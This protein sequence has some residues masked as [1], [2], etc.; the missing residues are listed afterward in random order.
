MFVVSPD[1]VFPIA[2][3]P[4]TIE[5]LSYQLHAVIARVSRG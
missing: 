5:I 4:S 1:R 2:A 3:G